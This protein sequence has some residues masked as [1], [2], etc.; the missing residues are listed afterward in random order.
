MTFG[1]IT[2]DEN[3]NETF[4]AV[5]RAFRVVY[6]ISIAAGA[7]GSQALPGF[8]PGN[9]VA[10]FNLTGGNSQTYAYT[11]VWMEENMLRWA[12]PSI[13]PSAYRR[14]GQIVVVAYA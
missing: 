2:R 14:P 4:R 10:F 13:T 3:Q 6:T 9:A 1:I 8:G 5:G 7:T 11:Q 12:T